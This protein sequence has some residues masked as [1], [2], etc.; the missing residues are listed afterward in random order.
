VGGLLQA[1]VREERLDTGA[2]SLRCAASEILN[3]EP[4]RRA[5]ITI[6]VRRDPLPCWDT[7]IENQFLR[8]APKVHLIFDRLDWRPGIVP[9]DAV[10]R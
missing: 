2:V 5:H 3:K 8:C 7:L 4:A 1:A 10:H 9:R 6:L